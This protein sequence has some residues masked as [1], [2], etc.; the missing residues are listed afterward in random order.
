[1]AEADY[2]PLGSRK[3]AVNIPTEITEIAEK[4]EF[5]SAE[6]IRKLVLLCFETYRAEPYSYYAEVVP[7]LARRW[8]TSSKIEGIGPTSSLEKLNFM[9]K[10]FMDNHQFQ[11]DVNVYRQKIH[12]LNGDKY[13]F[14]DH[15]YMQPGDYHSMNFPRRTD[16]TVSSENYRNKNQLPFRQTF[17]SRR[18]NMIDRKDI[19]GLGV[20]AGASLEGQVRRMKSIDQDPVDYRKQRSAVAWMDS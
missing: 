4:D 6:N 2:Y 18:L 7:K 13:G 16:I 19:D 17:G 5:L 11:T 15:L 20:R 1:M 9:N 8:A 14:K 10:S 3:R 12:T